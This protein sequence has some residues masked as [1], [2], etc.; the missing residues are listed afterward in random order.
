MT[1]TF[2]C[3]LGDSSLRLGDSDWDSSPSL[4]EIVESVSMLFQK[5]E[6]LGITN[7]FEFFLKFA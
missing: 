1:V 4:A 5:V 2:Y 6:F 3:C 7:T